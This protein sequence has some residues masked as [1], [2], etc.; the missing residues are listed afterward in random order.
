MSYKVPS[1]LDHHSLTTV[2]RY[3]LREQMLG[4]FR[5]DA[6]RDSISPE[7]LTPMF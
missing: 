2:Q 4:M 5:H 1:V 7:T 3:I 6:D